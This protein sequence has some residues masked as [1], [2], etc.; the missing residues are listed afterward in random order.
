MNKVTAEFRRAMWARW[1]LNIGI[2]CL[3]VYPVMIFLS[4]SQLISEVSARFFP[5]FLDQGPVPAAYSLMEQYDLPAQRYLW[6]SCSGVALVLCSW[7]GVLF[8]R[9]RP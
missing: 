6:L 7:L 8:F 3:M 4:P 9:R 2:L 5:S 1:S